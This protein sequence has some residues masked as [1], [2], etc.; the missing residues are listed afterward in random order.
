MQKTT[1]LFTFS[2]TCEFYYGLPYGLFNSICFLSLYQV[3]LS[4]FNYIIAYEQRVNAREHSQWI[5]LLK[6]IHICV[7]KKS[8]VKDKDVVNV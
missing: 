3:P 5:Y 8:L 1:D 7:K 6:F 4:D 2:N